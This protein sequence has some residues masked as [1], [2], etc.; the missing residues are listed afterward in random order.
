MIYVITS[1]GVG[2]PHLDKI[3]QADAKSYFKNSKQYCRG[4]LRNALYKSTI[5]I[6]IIIL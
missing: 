2:W 1:L 3:W 6:I 4:V 5:I